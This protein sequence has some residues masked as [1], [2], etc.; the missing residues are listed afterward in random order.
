MFLI[1]EVQD[2]RDQAWWPQRDWLTN[3]RSLG[4]VKVCPVDVQREN[5][6]GIA[7]MPLRP[8]HSGNTAESGR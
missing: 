6:P 4:G 7:M 2:G 8:Q 5:V 1:N 3:A